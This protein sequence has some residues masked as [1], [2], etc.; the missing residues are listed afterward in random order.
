MRRL[1]LVAV[2]TVAAIAATMARPV[3]GQGRGV[4]IEPRVGLLVATTDLGRT[5][6]LGGL[7]F[8]E[9]G[10]ADVATTL[11]F[12]ARVL[13]G[14]MW[15]VRASV[16]WSAETAVAGE[17]K[18]APSVPCPA[19]LLPLRGELSRWSA[20]VD[21][22]FRIAA[23]PLNPTLYAGFGLRESELDWG[24]PEADVTLPAFSFEEREPTYR[25]G[26]GV[27]KSLGSVTVFAEVDGLASRFGG[28][29]FG[30]AQTRLEEERDLRWD[31]GLSGGVSIPVP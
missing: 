3:S 15:T 6:V 17:W 9:F 26:I 18:C 24:P 29:A 13:F 12:G 7:G 14:S 19:V 8:G 27:E 28:H 4:R 20:S 2:C 21:A 5:D 23:L 31:L 16:D 11:G 25:L 10:S 30:E 1:F 22:G